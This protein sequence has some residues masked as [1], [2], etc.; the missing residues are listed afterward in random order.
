[1]FKSLRRTSDGEKETKELQFLSI[2]VFKI[3]NFTMWLLL[4]QEMLP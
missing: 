2:F 1:M 4:L 3:E